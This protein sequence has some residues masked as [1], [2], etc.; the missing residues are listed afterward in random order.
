MTDPEQQAREWDDVVDRNFGRG[1]Q[2]QGRA[3]GDTLMSL[4]GSRSARLTMAALGGEDVMEHEKMSGEEY[5]TITI[6]R[7]IVR[8]IVTVLIAL[9]VIFAVEW[10]LQLGHEEAMAKA[11]YEQVW[12]PAGQRMR[13]TK[14][15]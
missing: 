13:W 10:I 5:A 6:V 9:I 4:W 11:G 8:G 14:I 2:G 15:K 3:Q 1:P 7:I 12:D